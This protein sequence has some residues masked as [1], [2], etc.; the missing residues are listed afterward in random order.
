MGT[1]RLLMIGVA[2]VLTLPFNTLHLHAQKQTLPKGRPFQVL[3]QSLTE[4]QLALLQQIESLQSQLDANA[5]NDALQGQLIGALQALTSQLESR[6][7]SAQASIQE[8]SD[9]YALQDQLLRQ[10]V[11]HVAALQAQVNEMG[12]LAELL[13]LYNAQQSA[14]T[15]LTNQVSFLSTQSNAQQ[16]RLDSLTAQ[17][18]SLNAEY[19]VTSLRLTTGCPVNSSIRQVTSVTVVCETDSGATIQGTEFVGPATTVAPNATATADVFCG[20]ST[21]PYV[22]AGGGVSSTGAV[23]LVQSLRLST[24]GWRVIVTNPNAFNIQVQARVS[25]LRVN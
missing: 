20:P 14:L 23:S 22:A 12:N 15:T 24:N 1:K 16:S 10:Q 18:T 6:V 4:S 17:L 25:C 5:A 21:P 13:A 19:N 2:A 3:R 11:A 9:Y 8:L 7:S